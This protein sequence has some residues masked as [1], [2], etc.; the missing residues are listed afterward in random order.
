MDDFA[1]YLGKIKYCTN[2]EYQELPA[3]GDKIIPPFL[4]EFGLEIRFFAAYVEPWLNN[5]WKLISRRPEIYPTG[6]ALY[7]EPLFKC[8]DEIL[9]KYDSH[10]VGVGFRHR[11]YDSR[12]SLLKIDSDLDYIKI[13]IASDETFRDFIFGSFEIDNLIRS[14][15]GIGSVRSETWLDD[16]LLRFNN[17]FDSR[18]HFS[19]P[20]APSFKPMPI[21]HLDE[22]GKFTRTAGNRPHVGVQLRTIGAKRDRHNARS[23]RDSD[24]TAVLTAAW[25]ASIKL[26][27]PLIVYGEPSG[28]HIPHNC[29]STWSMSMETGIGLLK[30]ELYSLKNCRLM[31][32]PDSGW[33][34]LMAW[35]QVPT[36][37]EKVIN[38]GT[39]DG[40]DVFCPRIALFDENSDL[41]L[42]ID[43]LLD[44]NLSLPV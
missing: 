40:M 15:C 36:L 1:T 29:A 20:L 2:P 33:A 18:K 26:E 8:I 3:I 37:L 9:L 12:I 13:H 44:S 24:V 4:G 43:H 25:N 11:Y 23:S 6:Q 27:V 21:L 14:R 31:F 35:L 38:P 10:P 22:L 39:W 41:S 34:D 28:C 32:S 5:G 16:F 7:D 17:S 19:H 42:Q 30:F